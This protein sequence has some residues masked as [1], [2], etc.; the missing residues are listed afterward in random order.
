L[1]SI[2][3]GSISAK[4]TFFAAKVIVS[5]HPQ[6]CTPTPPRREST[7]LAV[8]KVRQEAELAEAEVAAVWAGQLAAALELNQDLEDN[9]VRL[10]QHNASLKRYGSIAQSKQC[11]L[12]II[13]ENE[14]KLSFMMQ[15]KGR[16]LTNKCCC[17]SC[18]V[19]TSSTQSKA[20][21]ASLQCC[22]LLSAWHS[23]VD[24]QGA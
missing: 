21:L 8:A 5:L 10:R 1:A 4:K 15:K 16:Q 14:T 20:L 18:N 13:P 24:T 2:I 9:V 3:L 6:A 17:L 23:L 7:P 19:K 12:Q 22:V 11:P